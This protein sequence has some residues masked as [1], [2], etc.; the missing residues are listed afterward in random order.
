[1]STDRIAAVLCAVALL[2]GAAAW[3][4]YYVAPH[5]AY[6]DA[7]ISCMADRGQLRGP[8]SR[9][10]YRACHSGLQAAPAPPE[11]TPDALPD[12]CGLESVVC[13]GEPGY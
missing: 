7:V 11:P 6:Y 5:D 10:A 1:M 4:H 13:P 9:E 2:G 12:P 8:G 3:G